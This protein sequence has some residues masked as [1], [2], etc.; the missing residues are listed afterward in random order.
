MQKIALLIGIVVLSACG[1]CMRHGKGWVYDIETGLPLR[2]AK[3]FL[4]QK[5]TQ[6]VTDSSGFF[7]ISMVSGGVFRCPD[8]KLEISKERYKSIQVSNPINDTIYLKR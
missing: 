1:D 8:L 7:E 6:T 3:V 4:K 5:N 2:N